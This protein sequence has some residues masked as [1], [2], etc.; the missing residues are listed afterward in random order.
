M[1]TS[2][3][4]AFFGLLALLSGCVSTPCVA[5]GEFSREPILSCYYQLE[6]TEV[7]PNN[8]ITAKVPD[9]LYDK[10][11]QES[12]KRP[13]SDAA[14]TYFLYVKNLDKVGNPVVAGRIYEFVRHS[15]SQAF[16]VVHEL[17]REDKK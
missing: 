11:K 8:F 7:R 13:N 17:I 5:P 9:L 1:F 2:R 6:V 15:N 3:G 4:L 12:F 10:E 16:E 14:K